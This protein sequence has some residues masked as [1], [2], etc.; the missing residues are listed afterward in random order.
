[1]N[2]ASA[3]NLHAPMIISAR[4][5]RSRGLGSL[6][7]QVPV[8]LSIDTPYQVVGGKPTYTILGAYP[9]GTVYWTSYFNGKDTGEYNADYGHHVEPNG[10][11]VIEG[12]AWRAQDVGR[13]QKEILVQGVAGENFR[14]M[15]NFIVSD[16]N[17][18]P[19]ATPTPG[20]TSTGSTSGSQASSGGGI[21]DLLS[22]GFQVGGVTIPY[23]AV[24][25][26]VFLFLK[27]K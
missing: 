20:T 16:P 1:M 12:G 3:I 19:P 14:A 7:A 23:W 15:V 8:T 24:G 22:Q 11:A 26:G 4:R 17:A 10:T 18:Q 13:W 6:G 21:S 9:G 5:S 25:I 27:K 2:L